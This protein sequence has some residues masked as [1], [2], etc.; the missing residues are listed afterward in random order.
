[1]SRM[2]TNA[3]NKTYSCDSL[4]FSPIRC[5]VVV[6]PVMEEIEL[7]ISGKGPEMI[8]HEF[9]HLFFP[10]LLPSKIGILK[11]LLDPGINWK[12][13]E[14]VQGVEKD[15]IRHLLSHAG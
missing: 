3:P 2:I 5:G 4:S 14:K 8:G 15:A 6:P 13:F 1:M 7:G 12:S 10:C 9:L 11:P